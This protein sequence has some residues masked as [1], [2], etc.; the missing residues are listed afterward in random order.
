MSVDQNN[1]IQI[2]QVSG[3]GTQTMTIGT[4]GT[5]TVN[6][7]TL[8]VGTIAVPTLPTSDGYYRLRINSGVA[9]WVTDAS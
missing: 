7:G 8:K 6:G 3:A 9:T 4:G 2:S 5:L 1:P